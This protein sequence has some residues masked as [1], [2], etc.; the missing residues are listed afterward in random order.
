MWWINPD[1]PPEIPEQIEIDYGKKFCYH[2]WKKTVLIIST[3]EDCT[4]CGM[5]KE[6]LINYDNP[7]RTKP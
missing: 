5:K 4:K 6:D 7:A 1:E 2:D 3:V